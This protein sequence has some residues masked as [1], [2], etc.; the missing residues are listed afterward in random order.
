MIGACVLPVLAGM[1]PVLAAVSS[2]PGSVSGTVADLTTRAPLAGVLVRVTSSTKVVNGVFFVKRESKRFD[3]TTDAQGRYKLSDVPPGPCAM[4]VGA[5][6]DGTYR[7]ATRIFSLRE[8]EDATINILLAPNGVIAGK[9]VD[10]DGQPVPGSTVRLISR[11]YQHGAVRYVGGGR[12]IAD[13]R[14]EYVLRGVEPGRAYVVMA[15]RGDVVMAGRPDT[16]ALAVS[17]APA[18]PKCRKPALV[19]TY[20]P[21]SDTPETAAPLVLGVGERREGVDIRMRRAPSYCIEATAEAEGRPAALRLSVRQEGAG[22]AQGVSVGGRSA[23]DGRIRVCGLPSGQYELVALGPQ[24]TS[25]HRTGLGRTTVMIADEDVRGVRVA[26][27][28]GLPL[29]G[30]VVWHDAP[31][32]RP[33]AGDLIIGLIPLGWAEEY[34]VKSSV[35]GQFRFPGVLMGEYAVD[36]SVSFPGMYVRDI[37]YGGRSVKHEPLCVGGGL[38]GET[39]RVV[40]AYDSGSLRAKVTDKDGPVP[41]SYVVV[42]PAEAR[43]ESELASLLASGQA[44]HEGLY[45]WENVPPGKYYLLACSNPIDNSVESIAGLWRARTRAKEVEIRPNTGVQVSLEL[46]DLN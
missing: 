27:Y 3:A 23:P 39:L 37:T 44:D 19:P 1:V 4:S 38:G 26:A 18:D 13:D 29:S 30:E 41:D 10:G 16:P 11:E 20:Y 2:K 24:D 5:T 35:P 25:R 15:E 8:G 32:E 40:L 33:V 45:Q 14:G 28:P 9:I 42:M 34:D 31:P 7:A 21:G 36:I 17:E 12:G 46:T 22:G 6:R 43:S